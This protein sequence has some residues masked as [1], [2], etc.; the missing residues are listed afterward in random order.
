PI[1]VRVGPHFWHPGNP[2]SSIL[3]FELLGRPAMY[4]M[5]GRRSAEKLTVK[6][7]TRDRLRMTDGRRFYA[8]CVVERENGGWVA[9]LAGSQ[10]SG[11]LTSMARAN[12]LAVVPEGSPDVQQGEEVAVMLLDWVVV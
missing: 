2:V 5:L 8:R 6:A 11:V 12:G 4:N 9:S 7:V 10:S 1:G 3:V